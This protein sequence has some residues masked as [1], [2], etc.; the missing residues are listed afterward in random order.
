[1][2]DSYILFPNFNPIIISIF[3]VSIRWYGMMYLLGFVFIL[4]QG[5][6]S[7]K[8]IG[9]KKI[10]IEDI[11]YF[12]FFG[13]MVGGRLGYILF[14]NPLFFF[15]NP[16]HVF[17]VWEGGMSFHGGLLGVIVVILYFSRKLNINFFLISDL[18]VPLVPVALGVGRIGNF[19]NG[20]LWGR[21]APG[22]SFSILFPMS[23]EIDLELAKN[24]L[25]LQFLIKKFGM[26]PRHPSQIYEFFLEGII[27]F[28]VLHYCSKKVKTVGIISS[29][30]LIFYGIFRFIVELFR[31]PDYQI[32]LFKNFLTMG[33]ILSI[34]MIIFGILIIFFVRRQ[35][36]NLI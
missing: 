2:H 7:I 4:Y 27:L 1:M 32:G 35:S 8:K 34:P 5:K 31:E 22:F 28:F 17:K 6:K 36:K 10:E 15:N 24:D 26:L 21:I 20:E 14:Y 30:F 12:S 3:N 29:M 16:I 23:R 25:Q 18:I 13:V 9:L 11:L 19:I 33:Q